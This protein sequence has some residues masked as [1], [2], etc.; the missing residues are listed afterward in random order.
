[1]IGNFKQCE[2]VPIHIRKAYCGSGV[3]VPLILN[4]ST[5]WMQPINFISYLLYP[6]GENPGTSWIGGWVG[7]VASLGGLEM[8]KFSFPCQEANPKSTVHS[9]V[10]VLAG[11]SWLSHVHSVV[12]S[13]GLQGAGLS[14]CATKCTGRQTNSSNATWLIQLLMYSK[15]YFLNQ[16]VNDSYEHFQLYLPSRTA[17]VYAR[18]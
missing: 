8:W 3:I 10:T 6:R 7:L 9:V 12:L 13:D 16:N 17:Q 14:T 11:L 18:V 5:R 1:V 2:V 4:L 15:E